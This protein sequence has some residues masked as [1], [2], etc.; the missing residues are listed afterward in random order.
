MTT[1]PTPELSVVVPVYNEEGNVAPL[2]AEIVAALR[3]R[4][5]FEIVSG[6]DCSRDA[7]LER[8]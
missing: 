6:D 3:G 8:L 5:A 1:S 4:T 7:T 2:V